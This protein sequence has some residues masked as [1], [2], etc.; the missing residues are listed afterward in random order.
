MKK[1]L[2]THTSFTTTL[3]ATAGLLVVY[4]GLEILVTPI[5]FYAAYRIDLPENISLVNELRA[6]GG[7]LVASGIM[8]I[9]GVF[10]HAM[11]FTALVLGIALFTSFALTRIISVIVDGMP[12]VELQYALGLE[13]IFAV[14][15]LIALSWYLSIL[16]SSKRK[17]E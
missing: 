15:L 3:L 1:R 10:V 13:L 5:A 8:L 12:A 7:Y 9:S 2:F 6:N 4:I 11:R 17:A 16:S 14:L